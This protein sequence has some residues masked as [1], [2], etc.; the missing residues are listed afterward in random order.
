MSPVSTVVSSF[1]TG[2]GVRIAIVDSGVHVGHPHVGGVAGGIAIDERGLQDSDYVDRLG[3]GTAI[4]AAIREKAPDAEL[5]AVKVFDRALATNMAALIAGIDWALGAGVHLINLSLGTSRTQH[6]TALREVVSRATLAGVVI[7]AA[8]SD[9]GVRWLP[10]SLPGVL[11]VEV[12]WTLPRDRYVA[13]SMEDRVVF[14]ASGFARE[15]PDVP[16]E[17]NLHGIS[18]AVA[19]MTGFAARALEGASERSLVW[20]TRSLASHQSSVISRQS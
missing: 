20:L 15:I 19:N 13:I 7:V 5:F 11:P 3:H 18:L 16:P 2:V 8:R 4:T 12:D 17:R 6:E 14:R 9:Q 10:G 1:R